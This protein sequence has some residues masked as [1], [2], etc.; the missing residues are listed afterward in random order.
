MKLNSIQKQI[1]NRLLDKYENSKS[2]TG[3][4]LVKQNYYVYPTDFY[5]DYE[6]DF[7]DINKVQKFEIAI[8]EL[9][10]VGLISIDKRNGSIMKISAVKDTIPQYYDLLARKEIRDIKNDQ[11]IYYRSCIGTNRIIDQF[12]LYQIERLSVSKKPTYELETASNIIRLVNF[13]LKNDKFILE[14]ELSI[15]LLNDSKLFAK[16][17]RSR[18]CKVLR[19]YGE[20]EELIKDINAKQI[21]NVIL[22]EHK[23]F[24]NPSYVYFKGQACINFKDGSELNVLLERPIALSAES[25]DSV[26]SIII[27]DSAIMTIENLTSYNRLNFQ[28]IFYIFLSGYHNSLMQKFL[29]KIAE[30]NKGK[31]WW[32]FGDIDPDGFYIL[33]NLREKT[34]IDFM[35]TYMSLEYLIKY[36]KYSKP[37][38]KNDITKAKSLLKAGEYANIMKYMLDKDCKL[39][40]EV[41]S[42]SEQEL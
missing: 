19:E 4:N 8:Y 13:I 36:Q 27:L 37:L 22:E 24:S 18:V 32:H 42:W 10:K 2:Y 3:E 9:E 31:K 7:A 28:E 1:I 23:I 15:A 35:P 38:E 17:F 6:S 26:S 16:K 5:K 25:L 14:R 20:Y 11:I 34:R 39:E 33:L 30:C 21:E 40:Q 12:C 29:I 41:I